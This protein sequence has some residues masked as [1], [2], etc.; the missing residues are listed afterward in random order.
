LNESP[1]SGVYTFAEMNYLRLEAMD[2]FERCL[3]EGQTLPLEVFVQQQ[4]AQDPPR[5]ELLREVAE[6]L[7]QR[8]LALREHH[9]DVRDR[10]LRLIRDEFKLD[11]S[12]LIP[13][14]ALENFHLFDADEAVRF[15]GQQLALS[16]QEEATLR[17]T[18]K[19]SLDD[20]AQ[21]HRDVMMTEKLY[22]YV[23]DW[24]MGLNATVTRRFWAESALRASGE[25]IH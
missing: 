18:L 4:I 10:V 24:V 2:L 1:A 19:A 23:M 11:L 20:A 21:L 12:P 14:R 7:H 25:C 22:E 15:L 16:P 13:L 9:F 6:D 8:L 5:V 17:A 3:T